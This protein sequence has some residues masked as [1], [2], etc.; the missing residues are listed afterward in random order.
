MKTVL[1]LGDGSTYAQAAMN[2]LAGVPDIAVRWDPPQWGEYDLGLGF[3]HPH[4]IPEKELGDG[5]RW[6]NFHPAPLPEYRGRNVAYHA[7][8]NGATQFG[9]TVH[10]M[11]KNFDTGEIIEVCRYPVTSDM[12]AGDLVHRSRELLV[13]QFKRLT[14]ELL[15]GKLP[16]KPQG[17]GGKYF[18]QQ[19]IDDEIH[20]NHD[21]A[22]LVRALTVHPDHHARVVVGG[23]KYKIVPE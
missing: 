10:Y 2:W 11:D 16:S 19:K 12:T 8:M 17:E 1:F 20:L 14:P 6:V 21:Q 13:N 22:S 15:K 5:K 7:I 4:K 23:R 3:L 9:S 18:K